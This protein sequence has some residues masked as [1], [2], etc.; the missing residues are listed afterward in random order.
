METK[1]KLEIVDNPE[2]IYSLD[3]S[4]MYRLLTAFPIQCK[5]AIKLGMEIPLPS[6]S[7]VDNIVIAGMGGSAFAGELLQTYLSGEFLSIPILVIRDYNL[8]KFVNKNTLVIASSYSGN[9]EETIS[10]YL[11]AKKKGAQILVI[12][13]GGELLRQ[14]EIDNVYS[15]TIPSGYLPR[16]ALGYLFFPL[17]IL[18]IRLQFIKANAHLTILDETINNLETLAHQYAPTQ[19]LKNNPAKEL[20]SFIYN[21]LLILYAPNEQLSAVVTRWRNQINEN[22]KAFAFTNLLPEMNHNEIM[23][24]STNPEIKTA[25]IFLRDKDEHPQVKKR[26]ELSKQIIKAVVSEDSLQEVWGS[27]EFLLTR[28]FSLIYLGDFISYYLAILREV[29]PTPV[30][31]IEWLKKNL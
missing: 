25:V 13:S 29:D 8:P 17:F 11:N 16:A 19:P 15:I 9:T 28:I 7:K 30:D 2:K 22:S 24:W 1:E 18:F 14:A 5:E 27:G 20:A 3:K 10:A 6:F 31:K 23:A 26:I 21:K 4:Q 12:T